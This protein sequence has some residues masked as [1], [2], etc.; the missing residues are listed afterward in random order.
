MR[1]VCDRVHG[2]VTL[3]DLATEICETDAFQRLDQIRQL[4]G[5]SF[6]Y[7]SA[8]HTRRE[9][10][11]GVAH[12]ARSVGE[13]LRSSHPDRMS[14]HDIVAL[15]I[16]GLLHDVGHGPFSHL[17]EEFVREVDPN[18]SHE[19]MALRIVDYVAEVPRVR[20][21]LR[22]AFEE[23]VPQCI[24]RIKWM[25]RGL[26]ENDPVPPSTGCDESRRFLFEIVH[27]TTHGIDV[28]KLDYLQ[29]DNL[30]VFGRSNACALGRILSSLRVLGNRIAF[31][32]SVSFEICEIYT[33]RARMHRQVYQ[34]RSVLVAEGLIKDFLRSVERES[35]LIL[36]CVADVRRYIRLT[37]Y[38]L[39]APSR[40]GEEPERMRLFLNERPWYRRVPLTVSLNTRPRC[41]AC[42]SPVEVGDYACGACGDI[43][44]RT[45]H[46]GAGGLMDATERTLTA[47]DLSVLLSVRVYMSD[48]RFG[49]ATTRT[50]PHGDMWITHDSA[51]RILFCDRT[52][53]RLVSVQ[54]VAWRPRQTS[55]MLAYAYLEKNASEEALAEATERVSKWGAGVGTVSHV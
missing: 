28:D 40:F 34:H 52:A 7:P 6:V 15:E 10:S 26:E 49:P 23:E 44:R 8:T 5:C 33:L 50:D 29:R 25:I 22:V 20:D 41:S 19:A 12:L 32:E 47:E 30:C 38:S 48:V 51:D 42:T 37:E 43:G 54:D 1:R 18:W 45:G 39:L 13:R 35:G 53:T 24:E 55:E 4:G 9:H 2:E 46:R 36:G 21:A 27:S 11:I 31:D 3:S 14:D 17:F 16:A